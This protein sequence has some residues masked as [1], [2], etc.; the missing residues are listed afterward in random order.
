MIE[1]FFNDIETPLRLVFLDVSG[2]SARLSQ[3]TL[4]A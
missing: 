4:R 3:A 2:I 1:H